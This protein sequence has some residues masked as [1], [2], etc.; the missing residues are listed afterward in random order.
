[1]PSS[2]YFGKKKGDNLSISENIKYAY[3]KMGNISRIDENGE[4]VVW[5]KYDALNRLIREDN[6]EF[7]KTWLYSY[8]NKGNIVSKRTTNFTLKED[9][10]ECVFEESLQKQ[11][12]YD[13]DKLLSFGTEA[14]AYDAIGNP[15][16]YRGKSVSWSNGRQMVSYNG[17]AFTYDGLGRRLSKGNITYIYDS[18]GRVIKQSNGIEFIYDNSGVAGI[19][20]NNATYIYRKDAQGNIVA[21]I[22]SNGNVVV[23]YKYDAWGDHNIE[24][25]EPSYEN[26][27]KANP[28]R[29]RGY[30]YDDETGLFYLTSRY[31]DPETGRFSNADDI[32]YINPE[33]INGLNLYAYCSNNPVMGY[34][35]NGTWDWSKFWG[36]ITVAALAVVGIGLIVAT[37]GLAAAGIIA[38]NGFAASVMVGAGV[39]IIAGISGSIVVQGGL[40]NLGKIDPWSIALSGVIGG[41]I[42]ALSGIMSYGFSQ[43]GQSIGGILGN[44]LSN[45]RHLS[46]GIKFAQAFGISSAS[47]VAAGALL[48]GLGGGT[49][50]GIL[51]NFYANE[52]VEQIF[53]REY[54]VDNPNYVRS[55][56]LK[57]F[58]W[59]FPIK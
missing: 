59:M 29:Y 30:Y 25:S 4:P 15:E 50:G 31:Y 20:Y 37:G 44:I 19:V 9:V 51:A 41:A 54:K 35:P 18:N 14:C 27:A 40:S 7:G 49:L 28:F 58:K 56:I 34:D 5:Y 16:T 53:G 21:L 46:T 36:W 23:E 33:I 10:E 3:D 26:L 24:L 6:K 45:A 12:E 55:G 43:I 52:I 38:V 13:G 22:D 48:G 2:V 17:T 47:F 11:Y 57:F 8:D 1:M 42:G 39:G 32:S